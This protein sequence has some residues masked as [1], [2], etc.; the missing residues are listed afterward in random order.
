MRG[1]LLTS[2]RFASRA[3]KKVE[4]LAVKIVHIDIYLP[5]TVD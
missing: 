3:S 2:P 1:C 4:L 5:V